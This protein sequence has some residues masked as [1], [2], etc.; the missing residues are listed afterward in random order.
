MSF[1]RNCIL[2]S[3][4]TCVYIG[5]TEHCQVIVFNSTWVDGKIRIYTA[6]KGLAHPVCVRACVCACAC[7]R[8]C[9]R[10]CVCVC[11]PC[12]VHFALG[13]RACAC[14]CRVCMLAR[15][16]VRGRGFT[17]S[18]VALILPSAELRAQLSAATAS[19]GDGPRGLCRR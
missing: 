17:Y 13:A 1:E 11:V 19:R 14:A 4:H 10:V 15:V 9:V 16:R 3:W 7:V 5:S 8:A 6:R 12:D 2:Y 18:S